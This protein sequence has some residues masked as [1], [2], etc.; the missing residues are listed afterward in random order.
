MADPEETFSY[1]DIVCEAK[2]NPTEKRETIEEL[3]KK[4]LSGD[5]VEDVRSDGTYLLI[6]ANDI[7]DL[8]ILYEWSYELKLMDTIRSRLI[9]SILGNITALYF[10]RQ[11]L[12]MDKLALVD[13]DDDPPLGAVIIQIISDN[14]MAVINQITPR[15]YDGLI[16]TAEQIQKREQKREIRKHKKIQKQGRDRSKSRK[17]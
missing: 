2:L 1:I 14:L 11:A 9:K 6:R 16:L 8:L 7:S 15:T 12:A 5:V 3:L 10:N 4:F 13:V 17:H